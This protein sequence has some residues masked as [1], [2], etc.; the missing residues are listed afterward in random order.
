MRDRD[1]AARVDEPESPPR[2]PFGVVPQPHRERVVDDRQRR[3]ELVLAD[4]HERRALVDRLAAEAVCG[5]V[6][7]DVG[8]CRGLQDD[9][10]VTRRQLHRVGPGARLRRCSGTEGSAV[11]VTDALRCG[12]SEAVG[13]VVARDPGQATLDRLAGDGLAGRVRECS[14]PVVGADVAGGL[15]TTCGI[16]EV[17]D[18]PWPC[19]RGRPRQCR[20]RLFAV[21]PALAASA[22]PG[23][24]GSRGARRTASATRST[25]ARR[26]SLETTLAEPDAVRPS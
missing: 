23:Q 8:H 1:G 7:E 21:C 19:R 14:G 16:H 5:Q 24:V 9:L 13:A 26:S 15:Q 2:R 3:V 11:E 12:A 6:A 20:S 17:L 10:V 18:H 4:V 22:S 25:S